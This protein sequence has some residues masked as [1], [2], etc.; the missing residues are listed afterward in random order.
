LLL[1]SHRTR[2]WLQGGH[3]IAYRFAPHSNQT[4]ITCT[5]TRNVEVAVLL[6]ASVA[7]HV[8]VLVPRAKVASR[9]GVQLNVGAGSTVSC[10]ETGRVAV[11]PVGPVA[12]RTWSAGTLIVGGM[13]SC[14]QGRRWSMTVVVGQHTYGWSARQH[15]DTGD[16]EDLVQSCVLLPFSD[17]VIIINCEGCAAPFCYLTRQ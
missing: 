11:E 4:Y 15:T 13:V 12:S 3:N 17:I 9:A 8:T 5:V 14:K 7:V 10:A 6:D 16:S 2:Y 1:T